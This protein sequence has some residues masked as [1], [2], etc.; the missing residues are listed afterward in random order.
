MAKLM[1]ASQRYTSQRP[2]QQPRG[3][4]HPGAAPAACAPRVPRALPPHIP[5][6]QRQAADA[7][8]CRVAPT[9]H[10]RPRVAVFNRVDCQVERVND[11]HCLSVLQG[12]FKRGGRGAGAPCPS[13][14]RGSV[15]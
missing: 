10:A 8:P 12:G 15:C 2:L 5:T 13:N 4:A 3:A 11:R 7:S 6:R 1:A 14:S 9:F